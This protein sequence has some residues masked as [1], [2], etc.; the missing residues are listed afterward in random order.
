MIPIFHSIFSSKEPYKKITLED[1][2]WILNR[3][4][5]YIIINTLPIEYQECLIPGTIPVEKEEA[6]INEMLNR[7][8]IPDKPIVIYGKNTHDE[9]PKKKYQQL[10]SLGIQEIYIYSSGMF[11]WLLLNDIYG[12]NE[13]PMLCPKKTVDIWKY[14]PVSKIYT[15]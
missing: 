4:D 5:K 11:E 6:I 8:D 10:K 12:S 3:P 2:Q 13:F 7:I 9:S 15:P 14:R 1:V